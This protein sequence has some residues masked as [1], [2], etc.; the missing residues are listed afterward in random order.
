MEMLKPKEIMNGVSVVLVAGSIAWI[1]TTLIEVDKKTAVT[2]VKVEEN[3][4][5]LH[6]LWIDFINRKT[7]DGNLAGIN[8]PTNNKSTR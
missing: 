3:H 8:V 4:K 7:I 5:M 2:M 6:T 1:V